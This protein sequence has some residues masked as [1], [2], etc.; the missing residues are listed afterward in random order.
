[1]IF[2]AKGTKIKLSEIDKDCTEI[3]SVLNKMTGMRVPVDGYDYEEGFSANVEKKESEVTESD[4]YIGED[5]VTNQETTCRTRQTSQG[6]SWDLY[7]YTQNSLLI[8]LRI[9]ISVE[10]REAFLHAIHR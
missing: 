8:T 9:S 5:E 3:T 1:M 7:R 6:G 4:D 2:K 10:T